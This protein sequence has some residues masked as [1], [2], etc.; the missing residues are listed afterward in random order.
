[1]FLL[2]YGTVKEKEVHYVGRSEIYY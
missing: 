1:M 2:L